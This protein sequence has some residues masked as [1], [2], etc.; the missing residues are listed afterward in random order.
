MTSSTNPTKTCTKCSRVLPATTDN[1]YKNKGGK[2]GLTP[3][4]KPCVND[5]NEEQRKKRLEQNPERERLLAT[6]RTKRS[7][8]RNLEKSRE[9]HR[10]HQ[11]KRREDPNERAKI[12]MAKRGGSARLTE[13]EFNV[14]FASQGYC[15]AICGSKYP[16]HIKGWNIDHC[17]KSKKVRFILCAHCNRGLGA[18]KDNS[19]NLRK[20]AE[21]LDAFYASSEK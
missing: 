4:C 18:F 2:F 21:L 8:F 7:Y 12:N 9:R 17:H 1:F 10:L 15:C 3:R 5:D 20:A 11:K 19:A 13:H 6:N 16:G 14:M